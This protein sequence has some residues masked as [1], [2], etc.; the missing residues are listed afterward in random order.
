M[1]QDKTTGQGQGL[2]AENGARRVIGRDWLMDSGVKLKTE[3]GNCEANCVNEPPNKK[4][5]KFQ[6]VFSRHGRIDGLE[7]YAQCKENCVPKQQKRRSIPLQHQNAAGKKLEKKHFEKI[8]EIK[9]GA[10]HTTDSHYNK[11]R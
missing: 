10:F 11:T 9:E 4:F 7:I 8:N 5:T 6:E 2:V 3:C 1:K